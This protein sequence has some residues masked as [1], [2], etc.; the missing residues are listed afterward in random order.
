M[1]RYHTTVIFGTTQEYATFANG[2]V[3]KSRIIN[4]ARSPRGILQF[5]IQFSIS[6]EAK[7]IETFRVALVEYVKSKP[8]EWLLLTGFRLSCI[9][10]SLG[11]VQ[12]K[13]TLQHRE[14]WQQVAALQN[15]LADVQR[16]AVNVSKSMGMNYSSPVLPM[17]IQ[18]LDFV[19]MTNRSTDMV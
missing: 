13:V 2:A 7:T 6:V 10:T 17:E 19:G 15:S 1:R 11:Y 18:S 5:T 4:S 8:R 16:H 14:S 9:D 3:S 12:Y